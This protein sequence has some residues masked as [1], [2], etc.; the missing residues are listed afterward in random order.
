MDMPKRIIKVPNNTPWL[1]IQFN[2]QETERLLQDP[3]PGID[4]KPHE[5]NMRYFDVTILGPL[6]SPYE[7]IMSIDLV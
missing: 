7:S 1:R 2:F 5:D 6:D 3:A 4:A